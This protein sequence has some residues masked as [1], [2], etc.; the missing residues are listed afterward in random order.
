MHNPVRPR[1]AIGTDSRITGARDLLDEMRVARSSAP[2]STSDV[3]AMVT[4]EAAEVLRQPRAGRIA[5]G[6]PADFV[7]VP[8]VAASAAG[9][10]RGRAGRICGW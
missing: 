6:L 4:S 5:L 3:L 7:I 2:L 1:V 10:A 8:P 9:A